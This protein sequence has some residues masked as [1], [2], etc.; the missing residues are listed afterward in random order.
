MMVF[1]GLVMTVLGFAIAVSGLG[2]AGSVGARM[3]LA[4]LGIAVSVTGIIGF[5]NRAYMKHAIWKR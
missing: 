1:L 5:L 3:A 2:A 4:L